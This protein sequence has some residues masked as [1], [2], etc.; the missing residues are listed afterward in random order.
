[1]K[2]RQKVR[3]MFFPREAYEPGSIDVTE[4][5][6]AE[7]PSEEVEA[8]KYVTT[9][10]TEAGIYFTVVYLAKEEKKKASNGIYELTSSV[11]QSRHDLSI[12]SGP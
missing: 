1:M 3:S 12:V 8:I 7:V 10:A 4:R 6:F 5:F 2:D 9:D 11:S